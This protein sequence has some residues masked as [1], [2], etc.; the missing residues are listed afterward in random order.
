MY[1]SKIKFICVQNP[2]CEITTSLL[3][4]LNKYKNSNILID[5]INNSTNFNIDAYVNIF[6]KISYDK[7]MVH[8]MDNIKKMC[9]NIILLCVSN[10]VQNR[11]FDK[12]CN[13]FEKKYTNK[14][15]KIIEKKM[16]L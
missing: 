2:I 3:D 7:S 11:D 10:D 14:V 9:C 12:F 6:K 8:I 15:P 5:D 4:L 16:L 1:N 13:D